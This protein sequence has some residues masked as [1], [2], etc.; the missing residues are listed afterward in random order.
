MRNSKANGRLP[1]TYSN[2]GFAKLYLVEEVEKL[3]EEFLKIQKEYW[4]LMAELRRRV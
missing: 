4:R 2:A 1:D 3:E